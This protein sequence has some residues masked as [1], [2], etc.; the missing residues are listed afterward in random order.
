[1][2]V[3][4]SNKRISYRP[5]TKIDFKSYYNYDNIKQTIKGFSFFYD[6]KLSGVAGIVYGDGY[7]YMFSEYD[8]DI[9]VS[10]LSIWRCTKLVI[11]MVDK[12]RIGVFAECN[13]NIPN[14]NRFLERLGFRLMDGLYYRGVA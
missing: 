3:L 5:I 2:E 13:P 1:M 8:K 11:D 6:G 9:N 10:K 4:K 7:M 14:A 12:M